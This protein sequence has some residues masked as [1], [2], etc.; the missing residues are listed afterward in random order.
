M[1]DKKTRAVVPPKPKSFLPTQVT[2][3]NV[4]AAN[5]MS[6]KHMVKTSITFPEP[7]HRQMRIARAIYNKPVNEILVEAFEMWIKKQEAKEK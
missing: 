2:T 5:N 4:G 6:D 7:I 3:T 1:N